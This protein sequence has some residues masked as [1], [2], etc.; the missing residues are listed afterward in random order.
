MSKPVD[1]E[2]MK[3]K[4]EHKQDCMKMIQAIIDGEA[5]PQQIE[6]FKAHNLQTCLPCVENYELEQEIRKVLQQKIEKKCCPESIAFNIK[7]KIGLALLVL[8]FVC[9]EVHLYHTFFC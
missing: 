5:T 2:L 3:Q 7:A 8:T 1:K 4:C 6:H 9:I